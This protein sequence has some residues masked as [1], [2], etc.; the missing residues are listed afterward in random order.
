MPILRDGLWVP[1]ISFGR[2]ARAVN[3]V[4]NQYDERLSFGFNEENQDWCV[5][6]KVEHGD[7]PEVPIL[8]FGSRVPTPDEALERLF[9]TDALRHGDYILTQMRKE[10]E[11]KQQ[12]LRDATDAATTEA[13]EK[14]E[15]ANRRHGINDQDRFFTKKHYKGRPKEEFRG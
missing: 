5:F 8:G 12:A 15:F 11:A 10:N 1:S 9:K 14:I 13:A 3:K 4:V 7:R 6:I 2:E